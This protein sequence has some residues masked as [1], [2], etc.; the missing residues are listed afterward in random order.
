[1]LTNG[2]NVNTNG[3]YVNTNGAYVNTNGAYVNTNSCQCSLVYIL[4][5]YSGKL[6]YLSGLQD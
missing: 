2:V 5:V 4:G 1:M 6:T 3:A